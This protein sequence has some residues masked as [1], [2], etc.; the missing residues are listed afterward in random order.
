[1]YIKLA[2]RNVKKNYK[3]FLIYFI[4]LTFSV[5]LFYI[6]NSFESQAVILDLDTET[7]YMIEVLARVMTFMSLIISAIF[8]FL[9]LYANNFLIKRRKKEL[10]L[11]TL[12]GMQKRKINLVLI[13]ETILIGLGS[14]VTGIL[15][16]VPFS[17]VTATLSA[18]LIDVPVNFKFIFSSYS[19]LA[20]TASFILIFII[21][22]IFNFIVLKKHKLI[23]LFKAEKINDT[24]KLKNSVVIVFILSLGVL[25]ATYMWAMR[26]DDILVDLWPIMLVGT[27]ANFGLF[28]SLS[29]LIIKL[30]QLLP[31]F[32][33]KGLNTFIFRQ[34]GAKVNS[35]YKMMS[36]ISLMLLFGIVALATS[37]SISSIRASDFNVNN[38]YD[39]TVGITYSKDNTIEQI[40]KDLKLDEIK[41]KSMDTVNIYH[42]GISLSDLSDQ[43]IS[44]RPTDEM[45]LQFEIAVI[46]LDEYNNLRKTQGFAQNSLK[47]GEII[48]FASVA[49]EK[50]GGV[51]GYTDTSYQLNDRLSFAN[52]EFNIKDSE[53]HQDHKVSLMNS[54]N[55]QRFFLVMNKNDLDK[56]KYERQYVD[57]LNDSVIFNLD[58]Y[59]NQGKNEQFEIIDEIIFNLTE[60]DYPEI[61]TYNIT[62]RENA[63]LSIME[64]TLLFTYVGLYLGLVFV[65]SSA[66]VLSLQ[67][68]SEASDNQ[69]RYKMLSKLGVSDSMVRSA[70]FNQ[71]LLYFGLP[72]VVALIHS[73]VGITAV[74][75]VLSSGMLYSSDIKVI[76]ITTSSVVFIYILYFLFTY[77]SSISI[78]ENNN[79]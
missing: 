21:V 62:S 25:I 37:F 1:M 15:L 41:Y 49:I 39:L 16:G 77:K 71:N 70:I 3:D 5:A 34:I 63:A 68:V 27:F 35:T 29:A 74:N 47:E 51:S 69:K 6:F 67:L 78:I 55:F 2:Y 9:I 65:I 38:P 56:V 26:N 43:I 22:S 17:Q 36:I 66:V 11:Y 64:S 76:L 73:W 48:Y 60:N 23:D 24:T 46:T 42:S 33:S 12:L 7:S 57:R 59:N 61:I 75:N 72:M 20:T 13:Y 79:N 58:F 54:I 45:N 53:G 28:Y 14:L 50:L 44:K 31:N 10:G 4:T 30:P 18:R 52:L 8:S 40:E 32:Y 19:V